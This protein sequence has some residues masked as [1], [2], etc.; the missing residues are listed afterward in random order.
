MHH[1]EV[2]RSTGDDLGT[3]VG[4]VAYEP[5]GGG[6]AL[7]AYGLVRSHLRHMGLS[8]IFE[9]ASEWQENEF[10]AVMTWIS[11][12]PLSDFSGVF[13]LLAE[14]Q[15]EPTSE[16]LALRWLRVICDALD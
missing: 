10:V 6:R 15:Q 3:Y 16:A 13:P 2:D 7:K 4:K 5:E 1:V 8:T 14:E 11:G 9:V 12:A